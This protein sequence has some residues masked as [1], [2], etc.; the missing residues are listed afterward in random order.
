M[1]ETT[2]H[3]I[4]SAFQQGDAMTLRRFGSFQVRA[5][6]ARIGRNPKT[7]QEAA[8]AARCVVQF[9]SGGP[10]RNA[11]NGSISDAVKASP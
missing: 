10:L 8:I 7:G 11:V 6:R 5:K 4:K 1:V 3:E 2:F 9:K